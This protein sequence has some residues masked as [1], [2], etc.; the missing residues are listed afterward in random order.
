MNRYLIHLKVA[1]YV[2]KMSASRFR[3]PKTLEEEKLLLSQ[4]VP[5]NTQYNT[6]WAVKLFEEWQRSRSNTIA[7]REAVGVEGVN[8]SNVED[9]RVP[10]EQMSP[11]SVNFW[12]CKF[13][14]EVAKTTG[15]RYPP[16]TLY[17][18]VCG[19]NRHLSDMKGDTGFNVL[20]RIDIKC[21]FNM[22][23]GAVFKSSYLLCLL[24]FLDS[25]R[26][27]KFLTEK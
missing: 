11:Y 22:L 8:V 12:L 19:I 2:R 4:F 17:L 3:T 26:F 18:L 21:Q 14:C 27:E 20:D 9:V 24:L 6:K 5:K 10:L 7:Q 1:V 13:I 15:E 25:C 23:G 16:K